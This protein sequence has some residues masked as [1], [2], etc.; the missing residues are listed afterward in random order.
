MISK[1]GILG[2]LVLLALAS[3]VSAQAAPQEPTRTAAIETRLVRDSN[4][5][6]DAIDL[7]L[8]STTDTIQGFEV[9]LQWDRPNTVQF[10]RGLDKSG[11][12]QPAT[13]SLTAMLKPT[14][15]KTQMPVE[16]IGTLISGWEF[17]EARS[18]DGH[19]AKVLGV[20]KL[21]GQNEP[22][23]ILPGA[24]GALL[25]IPVV[26][27]SASSAADDSLNVT[28]NFDP[29]GTRLST[30]RGVLFGPLSLKSTPVKSLTCD[31]KR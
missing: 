7:W 10:V 20:A 6:L 1:F 3:E 13:D 12:Q 4:G 15:P 28:L 25:R 31:R 26:V 9:V 21:F 27:K 2:I 29:A 19:T 5:C 22:T 30:H 8:A 17:I 16:R 11:K 14:D 18:M 24:S 23:P